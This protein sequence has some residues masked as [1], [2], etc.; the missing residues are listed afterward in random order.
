MLKPLLIAT[1][2]LF[3]ATF[4]SLN[5][6]QVTNA[7]IQS[8]PVQNGHQELIASSNKSSHISAQKQSDIKGIHETLTQFYR[9]INQYDAESISQVFMTPSPRGKASTK[10]FFD[11][12]KSQRVEMSVEVQNMK[13]LSLSAH[14]AVVEINLSAKAKARTE[15]E[16]AIAVHATTLTFVKYHGKWKITDAE[17]VM[18]SLKRSH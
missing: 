14:N 15:S 18:K 7:T 1:A 9:G 2:T 16:E 4:V 8:H 17:N 6:A 5:T 3:S 12:L 13:F 10:L 11:K